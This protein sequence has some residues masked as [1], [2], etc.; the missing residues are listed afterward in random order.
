MRMMT[1]FFLLLPGCASHVV[2]CDARLQPINPPAPR[3]LASAP[4]PATS[5]A[6]P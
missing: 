2:R 1:C 3:A 4:A 5:Q 6:Q